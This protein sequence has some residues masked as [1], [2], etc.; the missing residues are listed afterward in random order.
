MISKNV[1]S[2]YTIIADKPKNKTSWVSMVK[3]KPSTIRK[4]EIMDNLLYIT[5]RLKCGIGVSDNMTDILYFDDELELKRI[6]NDLL[7]FVN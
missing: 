3:I 5:T 6:Y 7:K 1:E 2:Y 4:V